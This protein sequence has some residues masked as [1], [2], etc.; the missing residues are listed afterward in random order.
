M[1]AAKILKNELYVDDLLTGGESIEQVRNIRDEIIA[2][3]MRG[4]FH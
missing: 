1:R 2:L 4:G 3:L